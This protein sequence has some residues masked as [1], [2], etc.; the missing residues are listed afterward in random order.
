LKSLWSFLTRFNAIIFYYLNDP[1]LGW[2]QHKWFC[3]NCLYI[4]LVC[5]GG[6]R[7]VEAPVWGNHPETG[8]ISKPKKVCPLSLWGAHM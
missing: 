3:Y 2:F 5:Q 7:G 6:Q 4:K 8:S 1:F